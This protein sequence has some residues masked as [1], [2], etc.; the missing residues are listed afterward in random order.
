MWEP[1]RVLHAMFYVQ[2]KGKKL[3]GVI[4]L[5]LDLDVIIFGAIEKYI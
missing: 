3:T 2:T 4:G 5:S 1:S